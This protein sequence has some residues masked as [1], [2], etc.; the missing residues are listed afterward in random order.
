MPKVPYGRAQVVE[1]F[2]P[3]CDAS[4]LN[5]YWGKIRAH[6]AGW[7]MGQNGLNACPQH[8]PSWV[9]GWRQKKGN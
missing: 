6:E 4:F 5:H 3:T 8:V 7:F 1:C 9:A 2:H